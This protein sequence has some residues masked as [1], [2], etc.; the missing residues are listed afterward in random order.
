MVQKVPQSSGQLMNTP[1]G[2]EEREWLVWSTE[3]QG[4]WRHGAF[5][6]TQEPDKAAQY[7]E[8]E[9]RKICA[10]ANRYSNRI[11]ECMIK[12]AAPSRKDLKL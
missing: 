3:H 2:N 11:E 4:F 8:A 6:Y 5:G 1:D 10:D 12:I 9:A 7:T